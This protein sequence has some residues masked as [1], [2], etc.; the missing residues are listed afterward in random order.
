MLEVCCLI[1]LLLKA[2][3]L[4]NDSSHP[5][6]VAVGGGPP[7]L[8]VA[9][10]LLR[11]VTGNTDTATSISHASREVVNGRRLMGPGQTPFIIL[12][13][14]GIVSLDV[15]DVVLGHFVDGLL[16]GLHAAGLAHGVGGEVGVGPGPVPV[17]RHRLRVKRHNHAKVLRHSVKEVARHPQIIPHVD[18]LSGSNLELPLSRHN[19]GVG[20]RNPDPG[21]EAGP[22]VGLDDVPA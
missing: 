6:G 21:V 16:D 10:P 12:A 5:V 2:D 15:A 19:F 11:H 7:I 3:G 4:H 14:P 22:V 8:Q 17:A 9:V 20:S 18:P 13:L 1:C